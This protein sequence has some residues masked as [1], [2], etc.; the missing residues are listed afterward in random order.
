MPS[1]AQ[2]PFP[3]FPKLP[4]ATRS[5]LNGIQK[6]FTL[7]DEKLIAITKRFLEDFALGFAEYGKP[8]AMM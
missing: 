8:M 4:D 2:I 6:Q 1:Q 7:S 5:Y 3:S